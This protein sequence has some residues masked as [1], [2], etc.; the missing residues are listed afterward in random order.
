[1]EESACLNIC[2]RRLEDNSRKHLAQ[3]EH[4]L[5]LH[6]L[7]GVDIPDLDRISAVR[8]AYSSQS[9]LR[10]QETLGLRLQHAQL[11]ARGRP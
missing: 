8:L 5:F 3:Q 11:A 6:M 10:Q 2:F 4:C 1:M 7:E 9:F